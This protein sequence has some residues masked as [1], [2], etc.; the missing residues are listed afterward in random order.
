LPLTT[1]CD[2]QGNFRFNN[3]ADGKY[4]VLIV[5][6]NTNTPGIDNFNSFDVF[7]DI[8]LK[9]FGIDIHKYHP[10]YDSVF[11]YKKVYEG[12]LGTKINMWKMNKQLKDVEAKKDAYFNSIHNLFE[13]AY[14]KVP[15][16]AKYALIPLHLTFQPKMKFQEIEVKQGNSQ[17]IVTDFGVTYM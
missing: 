11:Y 16:S 12:A 14:E 7:N 15:F 4:L 3:I 8:S 13:H 10:Y 9:Y 17:V 5:S 1:Q 6:K 2:V